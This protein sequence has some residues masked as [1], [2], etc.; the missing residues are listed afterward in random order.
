VLQ[1]E[2][3]PD[4]LVLR[5]GSDRLPLV[6][7]ADGSFRDR[8]FW[9]RVRFEQEPAGTVTALIWSY[10]GREY[11]ALRIGTELDSD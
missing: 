10:D 4:H 5:W 9:G 1:V 3:Q 2:P 6:P 7:L 11:R 8:L